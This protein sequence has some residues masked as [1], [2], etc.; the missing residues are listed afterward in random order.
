MFE[1]KISEAADILAEKQ[2]EIRKEQDENIRDLSKM[3]VQ[4]SNAFQLE[5]MEQLNKISANMMQKYALT[6]ISVETLGIIA[7]KI[8][9]E[10]E[11]GKIKSIS[12]LSQN[13]EIIGVAEQA[14]IKQKEKEN[15]IREEDLEKIPAEYLNYGE[16][17]GKTEK[18]SS[19]DKT[20][21]DLWRLTET[22]SKIL[23]IA[24]GVTPENLS[25]KIAE[26][27]KISNSKEAKEEKKAEQLVNEE[28]LL[29]GTTEQKAVVEDKINLDALTD[30]R[31]QLNDKEQLEDKTSIRIMLFNYMKEIGKIENNSNFPEETFNALKA[32]IIA[33]FAADHCISNE[34]KINMMNCK[35]AKELMITLSEELADICIQDGH[36]PHTVDALQFRNLAR[37]QSGKVLYQYTEGS[38]GKEDER[39]TIVY[40]TAFLS[41][42]EKANV[43]NLLKQ[44]KSNK[45][46]EIYDFSIL[47]NLKSIDKNLYYSMIRNIGNAAQ[48]T[49]NPILKGKFEELV[50]NETQSEYHDQL[51]EELISR[52]FFQ[53]SPEKQKKTRSDIASVLY[54]YIRGL[55]FSNKSLAVQKREM[56]GVFR[57]DNGF[58]D[59]EKDILIEKI[60]NA[61][62]KDDLSEILIDKMNE[63][64]FEKTGRRLDKENVLEKSK[65]PFVASDTYKM[66]ARA[67][68][69]FNE[70]LYRKYEIFVDSILTK[71]IDENTDYKIL[72]II[73]DKY[74]EIY[75]NLID[76]MK[77]IYTRS[78]DEEHRN[79]VKRFLTAEDLEISEKEEK[80]NRMLRDIK[81]IIDE[82]KTLREKQGGN[83]S[84]T[85]ASVNLYRLMTKTFDPK[86]N[87]ETSFEEIKKEAYDYISSDMS[88]SENETEDLLRQIVL[89]SSNGDLGYVFAK[90][91]V[92]LSEARGIAK[93]T[94][95]TTEIIDLVQKKYEQKSLSGNTQYD[96][97][98]RITSMRYAKMFLG[99]EGKN[100][101]TKF[102]SAMN[103]PNLQTK[104]DFS[105]LNK[106]KNV[107]ESFYYSM[108]RSVGLM[109]RRTKN[110]ELN[111]K[112][113]ELIATE[114]ITKGYNN[115]DALGKNDLKAKIMFDENIYCRYSNLVKSIKDGSSNGVYDEEMLEYLQ[116][117]TPQIYQTLVFEMKKIAESRNDRGLLGLIERT[118]FD[119][120]QNENDQTDVNNIGNK[121]IL[122][123]Q[124]LKVDEVVIAHSEGIDMFGQKNKNGQTIDDTGDGR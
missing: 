123:V 124:N 30:E 36:P 74:P 76:L 58:S 90:K 80:Q 106:A 59:E 72:P 56:I 62:G 85:K 104:L 50:E 29:N 111:D 2:L 9:D 32:S 26:I 105:I 120:K 67:K 68:L 24:E 87:N 21:I 40:S 10:I 113:D 55:N 20:M 83:K 95:N 86:N 115:Q 97:A 39:T 17:V 70:S 78:K 46:D 13:K 34:N 81:N 73:E 23:K 28:I 119:D 4:I 101:V 61:K 1:E 53:K 66:K 14:T 48:K 51:T 121:S 5:L 15:K 37:K 38:H 75:K 77:R 102:I 35:S 100:E 92:E 44:L 42:Q 64:F 65:K 54:N 89:S 94:L 25:E 107:D 122:T 99:E 52:R 117:K 6:N 45:K 88:F 57:R 103:S 33:A 79:Q 11:D 96:R 7:E 108:I 43:K 63:V 112:Y 71:N 69:T 82:R 60:E 110:Q 116:D 41:P 118:K 84:T 47:D 22:K 49:N 93:N 12:E 109:A 27:E 3:L 31:Q 8:K 98:S 91:M 18:L 114:L 19:A 16:E